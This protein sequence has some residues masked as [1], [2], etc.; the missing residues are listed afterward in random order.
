MKNIETVSIYALLN[1]LNDQ[2]FY[3]GCSHNPKTR[4][5]NHVNYDYGD[6]KSEVIS[7]IELQGKYVDLI[8]LEE[9]N[10]KDAAHL[11]NSYMEYFMS[12]GHTLKQNFKSKY[13]SS[14]RK[15]INNFKRNQLNINVKYTDEIQKLAFELSVPKDF[16]I[17]IAL[18]EFIEKHNYNEKES[19]ANYLKTKYLSLYTPD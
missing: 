19:T 18:K 16:L 12:L 5:Y 8:I 7:E 9:C 1:P 13:P 3:V 17:R 6:Y 11:E 14:L 4:L 10:I 2:V 15:K